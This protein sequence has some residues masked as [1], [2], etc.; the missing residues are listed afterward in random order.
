MIMCILDARALG[1]RIFARSAIRETFAILSYNV[2]DI[3][4]SGIN[5]KM[6]HD[7]DFA[8]VLGAIS[9]SPDTLVAMLRFT[10]NGGSPLAKNQ[11]LHYVADLLVKGA[12]VPSCAPALRDME[13]LTSEDL[14][15]CQQLEDSVMVDDENHIPYTEPPKKRRAHGD[16]MESYLKKPTKMRRTFEKF[17][18]KFGSSKA[19]RSSLTEMMKKDSELIHHS[20]TNKLFLPPTGF[21]VALFS[22]DGSDVSLSR[23]WLD[24]WELNSGNTEALVVSPQ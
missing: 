11:A 24:A 21:E 8:T 14:L 10:A 13:E 2:C 23:E 12:L 17:Y 18:E 6:E 19:P 5:F 22:R 9:A 4:A 3:D 15:F 16:T 1:A 20:S 7:A